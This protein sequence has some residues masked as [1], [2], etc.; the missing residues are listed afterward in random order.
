MG[1]RDEMRK[2]RLADRDAKREDK[3]VEADNKLK[4]LEVQAEQRRRDEEA[5]LKLQ[6]KRQAE[7]LKRKKETKERR[8]RARKKAVAA[9]TEH[10]PLPGIPVVAGS[11]VMAWG[12][13]FD[14]AAAAGFGAYSVGVPVMLEGLTLTLAALTSAAMTAK[15][16]YRSLM[17]WTWGSAFLA[18]GVN[19]YGHLLEDGAGAG[20]KAVVFAI[21]SLVGVF[22]WWRVAQSHTTTRT[23]EQRAEERRRREHRE[24]RR[25]QF[26]KVAKRADAILAAHPF[27]KLDEEA[28]W[29]QAWTD[30]HA[31]SVSQTA[32]VVRGYQKASAEAESLSAASLQKAFHAGVD[33][34]LEEVLGEGGQGAVKTAPNK[35]SGGPSKSAKSLGGIGKRALGRKPRKDATE[36]LADSDLESARKL[37]EAAPDLFSTPAVA[38]QIGRSKSYAK[39][40]RDAVLEETGG[41]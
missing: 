18:A 30:V 38:R 41:E 20:L 29:E 33:G 4:L 9:V 14:A 26:P 21:A 16:P 28:A 5:R 22:L 3:K 7:E 31:M 17:G 6:Q 24:K 32:D 13:Q 40:V 35:P 34:W 37:Y 8:A 10:M 11:M 2:D 39:R 27:G 25:K 12:G 1:Y 19:A 36:P 23:R 15:K